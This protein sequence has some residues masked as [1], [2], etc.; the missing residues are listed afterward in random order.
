MLVF[1]VVTVTSPVPPTVK[2]TRVTYR[3]EHVLAVNLDGL[4]CIVTQVRWQILFFTFSFF[5]FSFFF[6]ISIKLKHFITTLFGCLSECKEGWY[7]VNCTK[8]CVGHCRNAT[9]CNHVTGRCDGGCHAGWTGSMC[10]KG[11]A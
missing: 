6:I 2:T 8:P 10:D 9:T 3:V 5:K 4:E 1:T 11:S 7:G